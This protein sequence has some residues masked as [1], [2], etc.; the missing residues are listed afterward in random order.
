[1]GPRSRTISKTPYFNSQNCTSLTLMHIK[2]IHSWFVG[3]ILEDILFFSFSI[4][5]NQDQTVQYNDPGGIAVLEN[6]PVVPRFYEDDQN[7]N[8]NVH[9][10]GKARSFVTARNREEVLTLAEVL[11]VGHFSGICQ[12]EEKTITY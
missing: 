8:K 1:M 11:L 4:I 5:K 2:K 6:L 12:R 3:E 9:V 10:E 7:M